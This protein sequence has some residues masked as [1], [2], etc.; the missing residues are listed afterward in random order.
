MATFISIIVETEDISEKV[1]EQRPIIKSEDHLA[2]ESSMNLS[3]N[4]HRPTSC[5]RA[6][7]ADDLI[8]KQAQLRTTRPEA[9]ALT[10]VRTSMLA[11]GKNIQQ[12]SHIA[13]TYN[14]FHLTRVL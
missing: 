9:L 10:P 8:I 5:Y 11:R 2:T 1:D 13:P 4:N 3:I 6:D 14:T 7:A 12:S